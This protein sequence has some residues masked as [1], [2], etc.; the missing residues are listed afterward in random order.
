MA[1]KLEK[2]EFSVDEIFANPIFERLVGSK[3]EINELFNGEFGK[4][5]EDLESTI[6]A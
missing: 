5:I 4:I 3:S 6:K 2:K 1:N